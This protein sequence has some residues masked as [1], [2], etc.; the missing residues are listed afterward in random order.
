MNIRERYFF[1]TGDKDGAFGSSETDQE[2]FK[3][4]EETL[5]RALDIYDNTTTGTDDKSFF[6]DQIEMFGPRA[7]ATLGRMYPMSRQAGIDQVDTQI[8]KAKNAFG[9]EFKPID[10]L[11]ALAAGGSEVFQLPSRRVGAMQGLLN[12]FMDR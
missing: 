6:M 1:V 11:K 3:Y 10:L 5:Q 4:S 9:E 12:F 8:E 7:G 2:G